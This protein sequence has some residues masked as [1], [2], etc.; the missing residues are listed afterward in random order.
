EIDGK[1]NTEEGIEVLNF[2]FLGFENKQSKERENHQADYFLNNFKLKERKWATIFL[3]S[4]S[5]CGNLK[6]IFEK[7]KP[8]TDQNYAE[9]PYFCY[10]FPLVKFKVTIPGKGHKDVRENK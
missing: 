6:N 5:I 4:N 2:K 1:H 8:P 3:E 10:Q 7:R 9:Q